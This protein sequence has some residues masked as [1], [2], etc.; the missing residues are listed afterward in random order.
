MAGLLHAFDSVQRA[1][2]SWDLS[3]IAVLL[4]F[5]TDPPQHMVQQRGNL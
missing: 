4:P 5:A 1:P 2:V 3:H